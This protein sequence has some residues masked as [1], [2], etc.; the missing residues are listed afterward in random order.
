MGRELYQL[1][2]ITKNNI[3]YII[4]L[5]N[6]NK[7]NRG[8]L[9]FIDS[10]TTCFQNERQLSEYLFNKG[11]IPTKDVKFAIK[12]SRDGVKYL[13]AAFNDNELYNISKNTE[14]EE[15]FSD[16]AVKLYMK[17]EAELY[18]KDFYEYLMILNDRN[19]KEK[20]NGNYLNDHLIKCIS[21]FYEV[22]VKLNEAESEKADFR[23]LIIKEMTNYK[24]LRTLYIFY[25]IY[26]N[27]Y[28]KNNNASNSHEVTFES[29]LTRE[30]KRESDIPD[31]L[32][33]AYEKYGMDEVYATY[34]LDDLV[35]KGYKFR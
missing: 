6:K 1:V 5:N 35:S 3:E 2:A 23:Y 34:D 31:E 13:P 10:G 20:K 11:K 4:E 27:E 26:M 12:Y 28:I 8:S 29:L 21:D 19:S 18:N 25:Q 14:Q 15:I 9:S 7:N 33:N 16:Y 32:Q 24:Q 17:V 22:F 30:N